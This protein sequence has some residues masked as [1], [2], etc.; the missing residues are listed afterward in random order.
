PAVRRSSPAGFPA[1]CRISPSPLPASCPKRDRPPA[2]PAVPPLWVE[3]ASPRAPRDPLA[4][5]S[6]GLRQPLVPGQEPRPVRKAWARFLPRP[7]EHRDELPLRRQTAADRLPQ[8]LVSSQPYFLNTSN[9][10][11]I[12]NGRGGSNCTTTVYQTT[13]CNNSTCT[14]TR[15]AVPL[16]SPGFPPTRSA[17]LHLRLRDERSPSQRSCHPCST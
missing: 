11:C 17:V 12:A 6:P 1:G 9:L 14:A 8:S 13:R 4:R 7:R 3:A 15:T 16:P 2:V 10:S 5:F